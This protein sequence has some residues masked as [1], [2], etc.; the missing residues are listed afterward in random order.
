M[1]IRAAL[2]AVGTRLTHVQAQPERSACFRETPRQNRMCLQESR[3]KTLE[4]LKMASGGEVN[5][6]YLYYYLFI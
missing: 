2:S 4:I 5:F 3:K 1:G 6:T